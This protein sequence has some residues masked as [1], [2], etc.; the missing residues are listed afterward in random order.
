MGCRDPALK[1]EGDVSMK[2]L[3]TALAV[4]LCASGPALAAEGRQAIPAPATQAPASKPAEAS[5]PTQGAAYIRWLEDRSMLHQA[6][7]LAET[8]A[9]SRAQWQHPYGTPQPRAATA[10]ASVWFTA[11]PAST[12]AKS[13]GASVLDT[14]ADERLWQ[15]F[16]AIGIQGMHTGPMKRSGGVT[17]LNYTPSVDGNFDRISFE[18]DPNF[19]TEAQYKSMVA[20]ARRHGAIV[21][22][23]VIPGH[24]GKGP[25]FRLA[26]RAYADYPG[27]YHMVRIEPSDWGM[28]PAVPAGADSVNLQPATVDALQAKGYI[29]GQLSSRIFYQPGVKD[30]D[31]SATPPIRGV[32]GVERR[33]VYLHYFKQGQP[34][35]NWLDPTFAAERLVIGD[36][37][38]EISVLGDGALR[39]DANGL[40]GIE[41]EP[42]GRVWSEGHPLS[43]TANQLI[44]DMVR[45]LGGFTFQELALPLDDLREMTRGGAD[46]SYD[47]FTRPAYD[48]A[49]LTGDAE[50]LRLV[51]QLMRNYEVDTG[52]LIH[53]LQNHD[54]LTMGLGHFAGAHANDPFPFR[55]AELTGKQLRDRI[56]EEMY[57]RLMGARAPYNLKFG[58]GVASTTATVITAT[59]GIQDIS[60]LT[61]KQIEQIKR[62]HLLLAFYN[63]FQPGVFALSG[64]DLVGALTLPQAAVR[65]RLADG[66]TR[67][68]N[69][70]AYD[71]LGTN[72]K[73]K[74]SSAG[75]PIAR[76]I[77]GPLPK[78]L[79]KSNSFAS[80]LARMLKARADLRLYEARL[81]DL[82]K[83]NSKGLFV[84]VH[85]LP[86]NSGLEITCINFSNTP[87]KDTVTLN[88]VAQNA[89]AIDVLDPKA[90]PLDIGAN[91]TLRLELQPFEYRALQIKR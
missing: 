57:S 81:V 34:T 28:L 48:H 9:G 23:D 33:W 46:L 40:L 74:T 21:I 66:D 61:A 86:Q 73:A 63:A 76:A 10:R 26:E 18:I 3:W 24:T 41:R 80:Q 60:K 84:L 64:W 89:K 5:A 42:N 54:E 27:I 59:L 58:D 20:A 85:E 88:A 36:A 44:A 16:H 91:G 90:A 31:W 8:F 17:D 56:H 87:V 37:V 7:Q 70:G 38:H 72:P 6:Q 19:G 77:Y 83:V 25:D 71:L 68:I 75:L 35:L 14:L 53:A 49:L 11:Y 79:E 82:P 67:W 4:L 45:K 15:A 1:P 50:F 65:E 12:I 47:F 55:G 13:P 30:S 32:D 29:V 51:F 62:L 39:L 52:T 2:L 22:G 78:Q 43:V 69:R